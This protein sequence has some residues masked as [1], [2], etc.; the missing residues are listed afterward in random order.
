MIRYLIDVCVGM[1]KYVFEIYIPKCDAKD[2]AG[3][4][5][6]ICYKCFKGI[7]LQK[8]KTTKQIV[9]SVILHLIENCFTFPLVNVALI[10]FRSRCLI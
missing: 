4:L 6:T 5:S 10:Q 1:Q 8:C 9:D 3:R 2:F 7:I